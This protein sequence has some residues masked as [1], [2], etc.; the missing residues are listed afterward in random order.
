L[1]FSPQP[2]LLSLCSMSAVGCLLVRLF[3]GISSLAFYYFLI[4]Y[5]Q[6]INTEDYNH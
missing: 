4:L 2:F 6:K 3:F 5:V 1:L